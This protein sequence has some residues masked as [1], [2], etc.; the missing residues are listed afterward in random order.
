MAKDK[1]SIPSISISGSVPGTAY[2]GVIYS[3]S[4]TVGYDAEPTQLTLNVVLDTELSEGKRD[5]LINKKHLDLTSP[6][7]IDLGSAEDGR[8]KMFQN[9]FLKSYSMETSSGSKTMS[10]T[11]VDG[12]VVLGRIF[13]GL[14]HEHFQVHGSHMVPNVI[15][16]DVLCPKTEM[17][18]VNG[19]ITPICSDE[20]SKQQKRKTTRNLASPSGIPGRPYRV[21]KEDK[22][23]R[24]GARGLW[25]GGYMALGKEEFNEV[26]CDIKDVSYGFEDFLD[27]LSDPKNGFGIAIDKS[28]YIMTKDSNLLLRSYT[29]TAKDVLQNWGNDLSI[30]YY[31]DFTKKKPTLAIISNADRSVDK[32]V[33][34][35]AASIDE[36]DKGQRG[37][38]D[39]RDATDLVINSKSE[40]VTLD[41]TFSQAF[42]S[43]F[44]VGSKAS[45]ENKKK[46][47]QT[48]FSCQPI[49][50]IVNYDIATAE[51]IGSGRH[52]TDIKVACGLGKYSK[53][54][55]DIWCTRK[56]IAVHMRLGQQAAAGYY[57]ALGFSD[58]VP[59]TYKGKGEA[60]VD[61]ESRL[62]I[63]DFLN[64]SQIISSA[65]TNQK[66]ISEAA[67]GLHDY[68]MFVG[69]FDDS[70]KNTESSA[71]QEIANGFLGKHYLLG[72]PKSADFYFDGAKKMTL[73]A[74]TVPSS[75]YYSYHQHYKSPMT[76]FIKK[77]SDLYLNRALSTDNAYQNKLY[78]TVNKMKFDVLKECDEKEE[79]K[80][81]LYKE[82][83]KK[84]FYHF[85]RN[86]P[87]A[88]FQEDVDSLLNPHELQMREPLNKPEIG[89]VFHPGSSAYGDNKTGKKERQKKNCISEFIPWN[90][91]VPMSI[92]DVES[93]MPDKIKAM[94]A[95]GEATN[96]KVVIVCIKINSKAAEPPP[97][98]GQN[99]KALP[100][101]DLPAGL[102]GVPGRL[103]TLRI[104]KLFPGLNAYLEITPNFKVDTNPGK[105]VP[106]NTK[107]GMRNPIEEI[108]ALSTICD[109]NVE[110]K[111]NA[112]E[113]MKTTCER[114]FTEELCS[115]TNFGQKDTTCGEAEVYKDSLYDTELSQDMRTVRKTGKF[116]VGGIYAD[117]IQLTR[118]NIDAPVSYTGGAKQKLWSDERFNLTDS[119]VVNII[120]PSENNNNARI[121][122][123]RD[124]TV[125][126]QGVRKVF[127]AMNEVRVPIDKRASVIKYQTKDIT[128]DITSLINDEV[129]TEIKE[130]NIPTNIV[131]DIENLKPLKNGKLTYTQMQSMSALVYHQRLRGNINNLQVHEPRKSY[132]YKLYVS[133][134]SQIKKL[135]ALLKPENGLESVSISIDEG[136]FYI[137]ISLSNRASAEIN[138]PWMKDIY[139]KVG[140]IAR[141]TSR[142]F[143]TI[144]SV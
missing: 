58:V 92:G 64:T 23:K 79:D 2:G 49:S 88:C 26:G 117:A 107:G 61:K 24:K 19:K 45:S 93:S 40:S 108:N 8:K 41:G 15:E 138:A 25:A 78:E 76:K 141:E 116:K 50:S 69:I 127:D 3:A 52:P 112:V 106:A 30:S 83:Y 37:G 57:K 110:G 113:D 89:I 9:M 20:G 119:S 131:A 80:V 137:S 22:K 51:K 98:G 142:K 16:F 70:I 18:N 72:A 42:S 97:K 14:I 133:E 31:W 124:T 62:H 63:H 94:M 95:S 118:V 82:A 77:V 59:L 75:T 1:V 39:K 7:D 84:G 4:A 105:G 90:E 56:A 143:A 33:E 13:V 27:A 21:F 54:L 67:E 17:V 74:T 32:K 96:K 10:L 48:Y 102:S 12:S 87:W 5:F 126:D 125:T 136:G 73:E 46:T 91:P 65:K 60:A 144:R 36:L 86:A 100:D 35:A 55:R 53:D 99:K 123:N 44:S 134:P 111:Q 121:L 11:Y 29:G 81:G 132:S 38:G 28:R 47:T 34:L 109:R 68:H 114:N 103:S 129:K 115:Q 101:F 71:E 6:V 139:N 104:G 120:Y 66:N 140:P 128:Q 85:E 135:L 130:S 122:Y 43:N